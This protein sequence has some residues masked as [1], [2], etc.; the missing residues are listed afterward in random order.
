MSRVHGTENTQPLQQSTSTSATDRPGAA[1]HLLQGV[2]ITFSPRIPPAMA[3]RFN[4]RL[5]EQ[6]S[7]KAAYVK[8]HEKDQVNRFRVSMSS[9]SIARNAEGKVPLK[10]LLDPKVTYLWS[11]N[12]PRAGELPELVIGV[13]HPDNKK[14]LMGHA[15]LFASDEAKNAIVAG[16]LMF[17]KND[18]VIDNCSGRF[19]RGNTAAMD[20]HDLLQLDLV[21][22]A[23]AYFNDNTD[24]HIAHAYHV[25]K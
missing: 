9:N 24:L 17:E 14:N 25:G 12:K 16:E 5:L 19:G 23:Q 11:L 21:D 10:Q 22:L 2:K 3:K 6:L 20:K 15:T 13:E 4:A 7:T 18:W 8:D 1:A